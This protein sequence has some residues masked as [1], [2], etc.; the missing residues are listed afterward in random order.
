MII[1]IIIISLINSRSDHIHEENLNLGYF[2][3][4]NQKSNYNN[5]ITT[6]YAIQVIDIVI[7][8]NTSDLILKLN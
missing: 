7:A 1:I 2:S 3:Y 5:L 6:F 4:S 8:K